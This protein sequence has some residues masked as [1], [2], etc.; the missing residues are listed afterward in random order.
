M[1]QLKG[2]TLKSAADEGEKASLHIGIR[3]NLDRGAVV[4]AN[5]MVLGCS[6]RRGRRRRLGR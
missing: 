1:P 6:R 5:R 4:P 2:L 3:G